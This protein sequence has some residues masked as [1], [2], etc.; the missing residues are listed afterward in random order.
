MISSIV[1][2]TRRFPVV[3]TLR[4]THWEFKSAGGLPRSKGLS[5]KVP[6]CNFIRLV[7]KQEQKVDE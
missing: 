4:F 2:C 1:V 3:S 6:Q 5:F 7:A